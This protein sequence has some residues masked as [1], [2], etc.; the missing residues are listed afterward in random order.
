MIDDVAA[1]GSGGKGE[2]RQSI[3][4]QR[5]TALQARQILPNHHLWGMFFLFAQF[6]MQLFHLQDGAFSLRLFASVPLLAI[7]KA[8]VVVASWI[9]ACMLPVLPRLGFCWLLA[10]LRTQ[11]HHLCP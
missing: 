8:F 1:P 10:C 2:R 9:L 3:M 6:V 7:G 5:H 4:R 11:S